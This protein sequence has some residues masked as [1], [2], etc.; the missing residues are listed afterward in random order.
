MYKAIFV[1]H[2]KL[3]LNFHFLLPHFES[4]FSVHAYM[5][6]VQITNYSDSIS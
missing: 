3:Q 6:H 4:L 5:D 1:T 2:C